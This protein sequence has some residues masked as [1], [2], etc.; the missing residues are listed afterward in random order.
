MKQQIK[1]KLVNRLVF[2]Y[3]I[4]FQLPR[5]HRMNKLLIAI[6]VLIISPAFADEG[7]EI[8]KK[9]CNLPIQKIR[10]LVPDKAKQEVI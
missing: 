5:V 6:S 9:N 2:R 4:S 10:D 7:F 3:N 8:N 1:F